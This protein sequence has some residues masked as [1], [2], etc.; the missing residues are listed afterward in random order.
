MSKLN[1][2][3][4]D[5]KALKLVYEE[6]HPMF[7]KRINLPLDEGLVLSVMESGVILPIAVVEAH[8]KGTYT[9]IDGIQRVRATIEANKRLA[10]D[11]HPA[12]FVPCR[13]I[14]E[15]DA[16][17]LFGVKCVTNEIRIDDAPTARAE[18]MKKLL[19]FDGQSPDTV[20]LAFGCLKAEV[21]QHLTLLDCPKNVQKLVDDRTLAVS[22]AVKL[23]D[24]PPEKV[25][26]VIKA[27]KEAT[28]NSKRNDGKISVRG[29]KEAVKEAKGQGPTA[30]SK[31]K[32]IAFKKAAKEHLTEEIDSCLVWVTTGKKTGTMKECIA[33]YEEQKKKEEE[34]AERKKLVEKENARVEKENAKAK[35]KAEREQKRKDEKEA[36][37]KKL[38]AEDEAKEKAKKDKAAEK[39]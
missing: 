36:L 38:K 32:I 6:N 31:G 27:A 25:N 4:M 2:I 15:S 7:D 10:K 24:L 1:V 11:G 5:A 9:V 39:K 12:R 29:V 23:K 8:E 18:K 17:K 13:V 33:A 20:A 16:G 34:E 35:E 26:E 19:G 14:E 37:E 28:I 3:E 30:P 21:Q 22:A